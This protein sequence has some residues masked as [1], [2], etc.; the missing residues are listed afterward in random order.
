MASMRFFFQLFD[1]GKRKL[2]FKR[3]KKYTRMVLFFLARGIKIT[4]CLYSSRHWRKKTTRG[5]LIAF[6]RT[7]R[8]K[9]KNNTLSRRV[10]LTIR[11]SPP[12]NSFVAS[13][14]LAPAARTENASLLGVFRAR[15]GRKRMSGRGKN[16]RLNSA[17]LQ[18]CVWWTPNRRNRKCR[19][20]ISS[21]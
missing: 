13:F 14:F 1:V 2:E 20:L 3:V 4:A 12:K 19:A 11:F 9:G 5:R 8:K 18:N 7:K 10:I 6:A 17:N 16:V 21:V 15:A